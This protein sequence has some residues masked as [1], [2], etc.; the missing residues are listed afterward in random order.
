MENNIARILSPAFSPSRIQT[1]AFPQLEVIAVGSIFTLVRPAQLSTQCRNSVWVV[2]GLM[3]VT[4]M[5]PPA[6]SEVTRALQIRLA[7]RARQR[8]S[9]LTTVPAAS[10]PL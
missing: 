8:L 9:I 7:I 6:I 1:R 5:A 2:I 4:G 10:A 3:D